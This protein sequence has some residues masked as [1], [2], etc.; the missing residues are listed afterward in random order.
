MA[1]YNIT[2]SPT[3]GTKKA[4]DILAKEIFNR[5]TDIDLCVPE[6]DIN[7]PVLTNDDAC[8][9]AVPSFGGRVP[10]LNIERIRKFSGNGAKA[11]LVCVYGN[12]EY[13]DTL[14]ELQDAAEEAGFCVAAAVSAVAE[15]SIA[16]QFAKGRP[17]SDDENVL[18][19]F[20]KQ[21]KEKLDSKDYEIH[22]AIPGSHNTYKERAVLLAA[23]SFC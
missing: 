22:T 1:N 17:D 20:A 6:T 4:A 21:I 8:I 5:C 16:R 23:R 9:M 2:F 7:Y 3:G 13:E 12:R 19:G 15:H 11:I 18:K 10:E 14:T